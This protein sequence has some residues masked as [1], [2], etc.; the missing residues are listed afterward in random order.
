MVIDLIIVDKLNN[1]I[2]NNNSDDINYNVAS[3]IINNIESIPNYNITQVSKGCFVSQATVSRFIKKLGYID[4]NNFKEE[5]IEYLEGIKS[6]QYDK[7]TNICL[8]KDIF[9]T[10]DNNID[11]SKLREIASL[12]K[13]YENVYISGMNYCYLMAQYFQME[14]HLFRKMIQVLKDDEEIENLNKD[15]LFIVI[16][17]E[18]NYFD[19]NKITKEYL[20]NCKARKVIISIK[21]LD[22]KIKDLFDDNLILDLNI[23]KS[24]NHYVMMALLDNIIEELI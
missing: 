9:D 6:L 12:I 7:S 8:R 17:T 18:G 2:N 24:N 15:S 21:D 19:I 20:R 10:F 5:C 16:T 13:R 3:F 1:Y 4:Y 14:C 22:N 11:F 23:G